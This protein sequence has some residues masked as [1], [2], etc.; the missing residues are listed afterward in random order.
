MWKKNYAVAVG[1][2]SVSQVDAFA[3]VCPGKVQ[4]TLTNKKYESSRK[5]KILWKTY[6]PPELLV[7]VVIC[8]TCPDLKFIAVVGLAIDNI[9]TLVTENLDRAVVERP[10]LRSST[11]TGLDCNGRTVSIRLSR[12]TLS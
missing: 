1:L 8:R 6:S 9:E 10:F 2:I 11:S 5:G 7:G 4:V 12:Q 3:V